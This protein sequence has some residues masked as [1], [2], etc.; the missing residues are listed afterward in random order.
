[1]EQDRATVHRARRHAT[2][3][4]LTKQRRFFEAFAELGSVQAACVRTGL[5]RRTVY[6]WIEREAAFARQFDEAK[7]AATD[8]LEAECRRRATGGV[9]D[10]VFY[11]GAVVGYAQRYS[12]AC[13]LAPL[14]AYRPD[15]FAS[16]R[17]HGG[18][19]DRGAVVRC[20]YRL[21]HETG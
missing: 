15:R 5:P 18:N 9:S 21:P 16:R 13:L 17:G 20:R 2:Q 14:K 11:R 1:M 3:R 4:R 6:H 10:P 19:D 7:D 12:D 8:V